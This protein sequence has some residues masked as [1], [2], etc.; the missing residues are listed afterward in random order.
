MFTNLVSA[1]SEV[2]SSELPRA[3]TA[4]IYRLDLAPIVAKGLAT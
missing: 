3:K 4:T 1:A 2:E